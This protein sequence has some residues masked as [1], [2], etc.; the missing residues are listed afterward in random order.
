MSLVIPGR[1]KSAKWNDMRGSMQDE[2]GIHLEK[3]SQICNQRM[4][5]FYYARSAIFIQWLSLIRLL[6]VFMFDVIEFYGRNIEYKSTNERIECHN[7]YEVAEMKLLSDDNHDSKKTDWRKH[8]DYVFSL[9]FKERC[10]HS[11]SI[12]CAWGSYNCL[13]HINLFE[14]RDSQI[15][16]DG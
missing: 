13:C 12:R 16:R 11:K 8:F 10:L 2:V 9:T 1:I 15:K 3:G 7:V 14:K 4:L 6:H 5:V